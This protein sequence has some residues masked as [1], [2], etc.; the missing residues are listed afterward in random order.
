MLTRFQKLYIET[1]KTNQSNLL[2]EMHFLCVT[3]LFIY[4][5]I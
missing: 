3:R 4:D 2:R 5:G 1:S